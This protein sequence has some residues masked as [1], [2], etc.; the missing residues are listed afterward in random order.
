M[1]SMKILFV[2]RQ[3]IGRSQMAKEL[4]NR[5]HPGGADAVGTVVDIEGQTLEDANAFKTMTVMKELG[6]DV[7][8]NR[9]RQLTEEMLS[10]YD[11]VI[12]MSEPEHTPLWLQLWPKAERWNIA[13]TK[14]M[15]IEGTRAVRDQLVALIAKL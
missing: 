6:I 7:S 5:D 10:V 2:C 8:R 4:Y 3:N 13:D 9:R 1:G 14:D 12:I 15:D 11:K